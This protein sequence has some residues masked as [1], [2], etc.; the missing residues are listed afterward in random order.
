M[1]TIEEI[2]RHSDHL[3][4]YIALTLENPELDGFYESDQALIKFHGFYQQKNRDKLPDGSAAGAS[5]LIRGRIP[6][7]RVSA[8]QYLAWDDLAD[9][10]GGGSLRLTTRQSVQLHGIVKDDLRPVLQAIHK[11][12]LTTIGA[13]GDVV[14]NVTQAVNP[15]GLAD[16]DQLD[17]PASLL[18]DHFKFKTSAW[19]EIWLGEKRI[20]APGDEHEPLYGK[21][22]LPRK[23]KFAITVEGDNGIDLYTNDMALVATVRNGAIQ[24]YFVFAGGGMGMTHNK[25]ETYPRLADLVGWIP[26]DQLIACAEAVVGVH[27]DFSDRTNRKHARLKYVVQEQGLAWFKSEVEKRQG[28]AFIEKV[29]PAW[30]TPNYLGWQE[31]TDGTW[32]LGVHILSGRITDSAKGK[33]KTALRNIVREFKP[34]VQFTADQD[35]ILLGVKTENKSAV[36]NFLNESGFT[37]K[38]E[39]KLFDRAL[40]C[41]SLPTCPLALAEAERALPNLLQEIGAKLEQHGLINRA[42]V[43]RVTGCPNGCA[44]PY[45]AEIGIA[46]QLPGKY[47]IFLGG[48]PN[49][50]RIA[51][52]WTQKVPTEKIAET[53]EPLFA[54]WKNEGTIAESFGDY[55]QRIGMERIKTSMESHR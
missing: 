49:G 19:A 7:G 21:T 45:S 17:A 31:R 28:F 11:M 15:R 51:R 10:Y 36:E 26:A 24:G 41:V 34:L 32:A 29:L 50:D 9:L 48:S 40:A 55:I 46:G 42:P 3:R 35:L 13:C 12:N 16:L 18:S 38:S 8:E 5:F 53:L 20:E 54:L 27:R 2:K 14:R 30:N 33:L 52:L 43:I 47:A 6:G 23:F 4:G 39:S 37:W 25:P 1:P 22:Y 44:R